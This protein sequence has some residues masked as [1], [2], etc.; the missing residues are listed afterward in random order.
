[1]IIVENIIT[2][3]QY[4]WA[5]VVAGCR[6]PFSSWH[7]SDSKWGESEYYIGEQDYTL[8]KRLAHAGDDSTEGFYGYASIS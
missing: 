2:P 1:M 5:T 4:Q 6:N 8:M 3:S 7:K